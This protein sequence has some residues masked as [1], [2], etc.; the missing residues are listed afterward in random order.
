[1]DLRQG[2]HSLA[3]GAAPCHPLPVNPS[4]G[5][6][7]RA[8]FDAAC[9]KPPAA[10]EDF[11]AELAARDPAAAHEVR[12]L[13]A[14][15]AQAG[16]FLDEPAA[17]TRALHPAD[18]T[19]TADGDGD[20]DAEEDEALL[21]VRLG[22]YVVDRR[23]G[24]GGMG[25]VY[26]G[27]RFE[28]D[29]EQRVAIKVIARGTD[30]DA[31]A[32]RFRTE[33]RILAGLRHPNIARLLD[34]GT[35]PDGRPY[36]VLEHI[37][38]ERIDAYCDR[39]ALPVEARLRLVRAVCLGVHAAHR[40]LVVHRDIKPANVLVDA[41][42]TPKL[43]DFGIAKL[44]SAEGDSEASEW[45]RTARPHTP[46]YASPEQVAGQNVTTASDVFS[47]GM[48]LYRLLTG[49]L[50]TTGPTATMTRPSESVDRGAEG[51][52]GIPAERLRRR[53]EGDLDQVVLKAVHPEPERRYASA[54]QLAFDI[55]R[56]LASQPV[57]ARPDTVAYRAR[58]FVARHR[59]GV[60][61]GVAALVLVGVAST[62]AVV[63]ARRAE[64]ERARAEKR[65]AEVRELANA[66]LFDFHDKIA[67]LAGSTPAREMVVQKALVYLRRLAGEA[68]SD[69]ALLLELVRAYRRVGDVQGMPFE[70]SLGRSE[71]AL[72]SYAEALAL[73]DRLP[74][75]EG[76]K[77]EALRE[78]AAVLE[79]TGSLQGAH[80]DPAGA[81]ARHREARAVLSRLRESA[82]DLDLKS[83]FQ[84][85]S[86]DTGDGLWELGRLAESR[87]EYERALVLVKTW[88]QADPNDTRYLH[89]EGVL[90]QRLGDALGLMGQWEDALPY[91][92]RSL[93]LDLALARLKPDDGTK[94]RDLGTDYVRL[95]VALRALARHAEAEAAH[96][97]ARDLREKLYAQ[98]PSNDMSG[99]DAAESR[100]L[101]AVAWSE[102]GGGALA[103]AE[104]ESGLA[105][106]KRL[107]E[108]DPKN[109][110]LRDAYAG[111]LTD[112]AEMHRAAGRRSS[113]KAPLAEA[114][115][116]REETTALSPDYVDNRRGLAQVEACLGE[117][118][119]ELA[120]QLA[121]G[122]AAGAR[123]RARGLL[124]RSLA[125]FASLR[126]LGP[127]PA[128]AAR[129][130]AR[131]R[132][133][134]ETL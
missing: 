1:M 66:F 53:L 28:A 17:P 11:L 109:A 14:A 94:Q 112:V 124:E 43:L 120:S 51:L 38:G 67:N 42:G 77:P 31:V 59:A 113:A 101:H 116:L 57:L 85:N 86:L 8:L 81:V 125:G 95:G 50:P 5:D 91:Q 37:Q 119:A 33:R 80:G 56:H 40:A 54:D 75:A 39:L 29:F 128:E 52:P 88:A 10:R 9:D 76:Q 19:P 132:A 134:L 25:V 82:P 27:T 12:A 22:P 2:Y 108:A 7:L 122:E 98:D 106:Y 92:E 36:L 41:E 87:A 63:A 48:L 3:P 44:L 32:R 121:A 96:A 78:R 70:W 15:D 4:R 110:R 127:L 26:L 69:P 13:L 123:R 16:E 58:K 61:L 90:V 71:D 35:T 62:S 21:G 64:R 133:A 93:E 104:L 79:G 46:G 107:G 18:A 60:V 49:H 130:E 89:W 115:R 45:T 105:L 102:A 103:Q 100:V 111:A 47:L 84:T 6:E 117:L 97:R 114:L 83:E 99:W 126:E 131:A 72:A 20:A 23:I 65:F 129:Y 74:A 24:R 34:G 118:E 68:A 73:L 55:D 30:T